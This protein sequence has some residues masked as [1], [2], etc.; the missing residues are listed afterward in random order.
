ME[1]T[2]SYNNNT[3]TGTT[4]TAY[5]VALT[6]PNC[7]GA[8]IQIRNTGASYDLLYKIDGYISGHPSALATAIVAETTLGQATSSAMITA[9]N[10]PYAKVVISVMNAETTNV[11]T[12]QVDYIAY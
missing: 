10:S 8:L 5:V 4:T 12:Y 6:I 2:K 11:T 3:V 9:V 7:A 1:I